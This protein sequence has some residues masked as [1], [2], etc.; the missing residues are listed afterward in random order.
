M[1]DHD[2]NIDELSY[3][4]AAKY[5]DPATFSTEPFFKT[6]SNSW[7][8]RVVWTPQGL[9]YVGSE[10]QFVEGGKTEEEVSDR[11]RIFIF[12]DGLATIH[13][14]DEE[15]NMIEKRMENN[16]G[17]R[18]HK[19]QRYFIVAENASRIIESAMADPWDGDVHRDHF[20][21]E[22]YVLRIGKPWGYELHFGKEDDP[23]MAKIHHI[24]AGDRF[25]EHAHRSRRESYWMLNGDCNME[26]E[27]TQRELVLFPIQHG[28]GYTVS[29][30]QRHRHTG[31]TDCDLF[32]VGT[33][34]GGKTWRIQDDYERPDQSD[35][36]RRLERAA[37]MDK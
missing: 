4:E 12:R 19:G 17:Y 9:P 24:N 3:S 37:A 13:M 20:H 21:Y 6:S 32:E 2:S 14:D 26:M 28:K 29:V 25:S 34:E 27:N 36:Q 1:S 10:M 30:G 33:P 18:I 11:F 5:F 31:I 22:E 15:G 8:E 16:L 23:L 7:G 35:E